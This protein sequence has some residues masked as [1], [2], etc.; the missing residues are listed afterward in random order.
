MQSSTSFFPGT[1]SFF[2][3]VEKKSNA[4]DAS[5]VDHGV[6]DTLGFCDEALA[7]E[8]AGSMPAFAFSAKT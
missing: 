2:T 6:F 3:N 5:S 8:F 7:F 1:F 4:A